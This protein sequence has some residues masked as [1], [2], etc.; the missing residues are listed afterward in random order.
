MTDRPRLLIAANLPMLEA[1]LLPYARHYRARGWRVDAVA[2]GVTRSE[3]SLAAFDRVHDI[4]WTRSPKDFGQLLRSARALRRLLRRERYD[5][6]HVHN[7][8]PAFVTRWALRDVRRQTR[9]SV[10]YTA[11]GFHFYQGGRTLSNLAFGALER[12]A[13]RWTDELVV[14]NREDLAVAR[15]FQRPGMDHVVYM[16]GIGVDTERYAPDSVPDEVAAD[17]RKELGLAPDTV[18]LLMVAELN[19]GKRH[20]DAVEAVARCGRDN[21]VLLC[22]GR[23]PEREA[24]EAQA[25]ELGVASRIR[26]LGYR[27]DIATLLRASDGLVLPSEREG[28]PR[29][30]M[31]ALCLERPVIAT[32]IRGVTELVSNEN[33]ILCE[34]G[35]LD[36]LGEAMRFL[37]D[38]PR[39]RAEMGRRGRAAMADFDL[40]TVIHLHDELYERVLGERAHPA[41]TV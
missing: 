23:G 17:L 40:R 3:P 26:L 25:R 24:I 35:D 37:A 19:A 13:S 20:R 15:G 18:V 29:S 11:H 27:N 36:A 30:V 1:F 7:P 9:T 4:A 10:I 38:H 16:P 5:I 39:E 33:G 41:P 21:I 12:L 22:A 2:N 28:L 32:R 6:V 14:I 34:V 8:I 31:E